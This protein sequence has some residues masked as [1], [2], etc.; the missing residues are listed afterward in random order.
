MFLL[1]ILRVNKFVRLSVAIFEAAI[2]V[3]SMYMI[4]RD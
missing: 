4:N 2:Q 1:N 3:K